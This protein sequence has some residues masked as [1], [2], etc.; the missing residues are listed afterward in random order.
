MIPIKKVERMFFSVR[1][2]F[3]AIQGQHRQATWAYFIGSSE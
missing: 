2:D 1:V 3:V